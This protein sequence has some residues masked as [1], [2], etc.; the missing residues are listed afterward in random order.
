MRNPRCISVAEL[1]FGLSTTGAIVTAVVRV[2]DLA[3]SRRGL[4]A[5]AVTVYQ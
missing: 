1:S 2:I 5:L 3:T 4:R